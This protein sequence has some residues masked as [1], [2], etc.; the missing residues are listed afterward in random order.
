MRFPRVKLALKV[1][2]SKERKG[3]EIHLSLNAT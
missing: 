2:W 3:L 1:V